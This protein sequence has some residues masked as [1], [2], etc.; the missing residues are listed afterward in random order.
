M[1][2]IPYNPST[3]GFHSVEPCRENSWYVRFTEEDIE[4]LAHYAF[5]M[6][7]SLEPETEESDPQHPLRFKVTC[8]SN[9]KKYGWIAK[10]VE[11]SSN[12]FEEKFLYGF[13]RNGSFR[14]KYPITFNIQSRQMRGVLKRK[15][16]RNPSLKT[17]FRT[18]YGILS[19]EPEV[20]P[21]D[22]IFSWLYDT[23]IVYV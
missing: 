3:V 18:L 8:K 15:A 6:G 13:Y 22:F 5:D 19:L 17:Y 1:N 21:L 7:Y 4:L 2:T 11:I 20:H 9:P 16:E 10:V 14:V 23:N 12:G